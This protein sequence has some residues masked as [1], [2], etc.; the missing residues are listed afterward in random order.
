M[1]APENALSMVRA[2]TNHLYMLVGIFSF[3]GWAPM[4]LEWRC[5]EGSEADQKL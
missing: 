3:G 5:A 1:A 4:E 2:K